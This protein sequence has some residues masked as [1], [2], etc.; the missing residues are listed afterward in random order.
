MHSVIHEQFKYN[1]NYGSE[2]DELFA[3]LHLVGDYRHNPVAIQTVCESSTSQFYLTLSG[4]EPS[5]MAT[6][7]KPVDSIG[8]RT[9]IIEDVAVRQK[10]RGQNI[11]S[12]LVDH[13]IDA[14]IFLGA[15]RIELHSKDIRVDARRLYMGRGFEIVD[16][17]LFRKEL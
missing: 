11:G 1:P 14:S 17:N 5:G 15:S 16:T 3:S 8:H 7:I 9:A 2:Y 13:L 12:M 10:F 6:L 4:T